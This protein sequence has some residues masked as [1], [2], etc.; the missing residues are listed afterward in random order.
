MTA[1]V[2]F[3]WQCIKPYAFKLALILA[4]VLTVL[5]VLARFKRAGR[6]QER[7]EQMERVVK[8]EKRRREIEYAAREDSRRSGVS[9]VDELQRDWSRD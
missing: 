7:V 1:V 6:T 5:A 4:G 3:I 2:L 8:A 9:A